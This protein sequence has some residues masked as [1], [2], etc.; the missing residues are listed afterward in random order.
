MKTPEQRKAA[1]DKYN[2][3]E[4]GR[5]ARARYATTVKGR[6]TDSRKASKEH[7]RRQAATL[8]LAT[9]HRMP[10]LVTEEEIACDPLFTAEQAALILGRSAAA[11]RQRR[12]LI[13][14]RN[15]TDGVTD[16]RRDSVT[17]TV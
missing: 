2:H 10:W 4:K 15:R 9:Q 5:A 3:S 1:V 12:R 7:D 6:A 8:P 16:E 14:L 17:W 11:V 13:T